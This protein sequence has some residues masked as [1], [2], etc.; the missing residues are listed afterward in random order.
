MI[1]KLIYWLFKPIFLKH[2]FNDQPKVKGFENMQK[3]FIDS[4][5]MSYYAPLNDFDYPHERVKELEY[6]LMR[7]RSGISDEEL[8]KIL[9]A[10]ETALNSGKKSDLSMIGFTIIEMR[11]RKDIILH[12]DL[13]M[14]IAALRYIREDE[15]PEKIDKVI[16]QEKINQFKKDSGSGLYDFFYKAGFKKYIPYLDKLEK[17]WIEY[18]MDSEIKIKALNQVLQAYISK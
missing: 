1:G 15:L 2:Y 3:V 14:D 10:Q 9:E 6:K 11:K 18:M 12:P 8:D 16:H 5:G 4:N 17:D 13:M 7:L